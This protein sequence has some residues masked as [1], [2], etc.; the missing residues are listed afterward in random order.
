MV[1]ALAIADALR[2]E[3]P[4]TVFP[5]GTTGPGTHLLPFRS[6]LIEAAAFAERDVE[7][8]PV[9]VDYGDAAVEVA[10]HHE[11]TK[12]NVVRILRRTGS[13]PVS[14]RLLDPLPRELDRKQLAARARAQIAAAL[15]LQVDAH[16]PYS[17]GE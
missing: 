6:T 3:Q 7:I 2:G 1:P 10:W 8:R 17:P 15:G 16:L 9:A 5:E 4:V 12:R 14:V 11:P 13:L